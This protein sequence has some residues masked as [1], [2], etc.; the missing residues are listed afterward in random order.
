[1]FKLDVVGGSLHPAY[2]RWH[3]MLDRCYNKNHPRYKTYGEKGIRVC[4][5]WHLFSNYMKWFD[6]NNID[7]YEVDKDFCGLKLY[8]PE[9][10]RFVSKSDNSREAMTRR[11][12]SDLRKDNEYYSITPVQRANFTRGCVRAGINPDDFEEIDSGVKNKQGRRLF[13]Y[14]LKK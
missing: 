12:Y 3:S 1:M 9:T 11:D 4:D 7:G 2:N 8:S 13:I 5:E 14:K 10:C 6:E